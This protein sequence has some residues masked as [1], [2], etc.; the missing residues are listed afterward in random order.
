[1]SE[2]RKYVLI[3]SAQIVTAQVRHN[4]V[5]SGAVPDLIRNVYNT[6]LDV[7]HAVSHGPE[8][9]IHRHDDIDGHVDAH[10]TSEASVA[11][12]VY[13]HPTYGQTVFADR[14]LCMECGLTMK[15]LKRHLLAVHG[16]TPEE[17]RGKWELPSNYPMVAAEYAK[18]RSSLALESGLG[19][20]PDARAGRQRKSRG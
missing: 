13:E 11:D 14:L 1:M 4:D 12:N 19:L 15:M 5:A 16:M 2:L 9:G 17:Y 10:D 20:K 6:L 7:G 8:L 18:L 3:L